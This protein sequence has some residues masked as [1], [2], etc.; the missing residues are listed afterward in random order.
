MELEINLEAKYLKKEN[1]FLIKLFQVGIKL[2]S[3]Y[4]YREISTFDSLIF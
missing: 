1:Y 3:L 4:P 2:V